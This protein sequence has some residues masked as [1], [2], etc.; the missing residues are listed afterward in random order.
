M[1]QT[2][3]NRKKYG[4]KVLDGDYLKIDTTSIKHIDIIDVATSVDKLIGSGVTSVN[5][6][7]KLMGMPKIDEGW[8]NAHYLTKNYSTFEEL[9]KN[10][11]GGE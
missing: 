8:A 6:I 3:I 9:L 10:A 1:I 7:L 5:D 4:K 11:K 2:E